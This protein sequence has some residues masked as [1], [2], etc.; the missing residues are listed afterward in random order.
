MPLSARVKLLNRSFVPRPLPVDINDHFALT[1][2]LMARRALSP[3]SDATRGLCAAMLRRLDNINDAHRRGAAKV[4]LAAQVNLPAM[5][6]EK[7]NNKEPRHLLAAVDS[8]CVLASQRDTELPPYAGAFVKTASLCFHF[9]KAC[10]VIVNAPPAPIKVHAKN[11]SLDRL[12]RGFEEVE[13]A[14]RDSWE[15]ADAENVALKTLVQGTS[16]RDKLAKLHPFW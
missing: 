11:I 4:G 14:V 8:H 9:Q 7:A 5:V 10:H 6:L 15:V 3:M 16:K 2:A 1:R 13:D 12:P